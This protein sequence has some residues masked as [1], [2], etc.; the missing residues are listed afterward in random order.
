MASDRSRDYT[1]YIPLV[2]ANFSQHFQILEHHCQT[3]IEEEEGER[4]EKEGEKRKRERGR[5]ERGGRRKKERK[6]GGR[7]EEEKRSVGSR[8]RVPRNIVIP[9]ASIVRLGYD[10]LPQTL[11]QTLCPVCRRKT[12]QLYEQD[13]SYNSSM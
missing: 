9:R 4:G 11:A 10:D 3:L 8:P 7:G 5:K 6:E 2:W 12:F 1:I 13:W